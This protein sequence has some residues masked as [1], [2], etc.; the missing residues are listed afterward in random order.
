MA[1]LLGQLSPPLLLAVAWVLLLAEA[2]LL[3]G[4]ALPG[5]SVLVALGYFSHLGVVPLGGAVAVAACAA[6]VGT[7][8]SY[9]WGRRREGA[10]SFHRLAPGRWDRPRELVGRYGGWAVA[11][12]QWFGSALTLTPRLAGWA[13][14]PYR[15][16]V[17]VSLPTACAWASTLVTLSYHLAPE[18]IQQVT[19]HLTI[20]G[21]ALV[22]VWLLVA[23]VLRARLRPG[24]GAGRRGVRSGYAGPERRR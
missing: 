16:F 17:T 20:A 12:G 4:V 2:G 10:P 9:L 19:T 22:A 24:A 1:D 8:V 11:G 21:P 13:G 5:T 18:I 3:V 6:V 23:W 7:Q 15:T 14:M